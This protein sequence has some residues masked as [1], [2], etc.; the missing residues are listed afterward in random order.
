MKKTSPPQG[1]SQI[2]KIPLKSINKCRV[3]FR[4]PSE[5]AAGAKKVCLV[6]DFN[7]WNPGAH[8]MKIFKNGACSITLDLEPGREYQ[9]RFLIDDARWENDAFADKYGPSPYAGIDNSV[10]IL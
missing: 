4:L 9:Y 3:T 8:P 1:P 5:A 10:V 2:K 6:G 7:G